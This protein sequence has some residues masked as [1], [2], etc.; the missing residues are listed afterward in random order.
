[1]VETLLYDNIMY[2]KVR[3]L[4]NLIILG[5]KELFII[6]VDITVL[7]FQRAKLL[8]TSNLKLLLSTISNNVLFTVYT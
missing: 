8:Q 4:F 1:M 7:L 6:E 3:M 2:Y 5:I